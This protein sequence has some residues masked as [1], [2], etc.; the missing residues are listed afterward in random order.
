MLAPQGS[1]LPLDYAHESNESS[2]GKLLEFSGKKARE[3]AINILHQHPKANS[4]WI[5]KN[6]H[7]LAREIRLAKINRKK[8]LFVNGG[9]DSNW[10]LFSFLR[11]RI[12]TVLIFSA[13]YSARERRILRRAAQHYGTEIVLLNPNQA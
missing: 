2:A 4:V 12:F 13:P 3:A 1:L 10:A 6:L 5:E 9:S 11:M 8:V 7:P